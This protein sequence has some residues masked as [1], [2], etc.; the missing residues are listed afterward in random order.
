MLKLIG[1]CILLFTS[2]LISREL[3]RQRQRRLAVFEELLRFVGF[4]R[5]Q[6]GCFLRP[7]PEVVANFHSDE[8][9]ACGFLPL[10]DGADLE[11]AFSSSDAPRIVGTE[12]ARV[13]E[14][15]FSSLGTGYLED[16]IKLI[17]AHRAQLSELV[18]GERAES[19]RRVRLVRTLTASVSLG[20]I[21]LIV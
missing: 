19:A 11:S 18:E 15:L 17:D 8:L 16:E 20:L 1:I 12:C 10:A 21:I 14:S 9:C 13:A 6:I 2:I 7:V 5:L 3:V 4:L